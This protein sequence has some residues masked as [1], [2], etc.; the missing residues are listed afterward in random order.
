MYVARIPLG[1]AIIV[2]SYVA[3]VVFV[4]DYYYYDYYDY[5]YYY[6]LFSLWFYCSGDPQPGGAYVPSNFDGHD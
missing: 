3:L 5:D 2:I 4:I 6:L 1:Y